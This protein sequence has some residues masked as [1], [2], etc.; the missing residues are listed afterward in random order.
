MSLSFCKLS[1]SSVFK[2]DTET[3]F[4]GNECC[5]P[6]G[7]FTSKEAKGILVP[8]AQLSIRILVKIS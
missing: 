1:C 5:V 7:V 8:I 3:E 6:I 2:I 4:R